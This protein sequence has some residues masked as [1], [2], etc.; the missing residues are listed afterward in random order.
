MPWDED[1]TKIHEITSTFPKYGGCESPQD[2][3]RFMNKTREMTFFNAQWS[4]NPSQNFERWKGPDTAVSWQSQ[5]DLYSGWE[6]WKTDQ[7][8]A[9]QRVGDNGCIPGILWHLSFSLRFFWFRP[10]VSCGHHAKKSSPEGVGH[11]HHLI[12]QGAHNLPTTSD[13]WRTSNRQNWG[14]IH[15]T[16]WLEK[17]QSWKLGCVYVYI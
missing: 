14:M 1:S 4:I 10:D 16:K 7:G 9:W 6:A 8:L 13:N 5:D 17:I 3:S 15:L 11:R 2:V 12:T